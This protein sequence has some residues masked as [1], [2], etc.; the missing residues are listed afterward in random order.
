MERLKFQLNALNNLLKLAENT[1]SE[2][3]INEL[4]SDINYIQKQI[5]KKI[6]RDREKI[7]ISLINDI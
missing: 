2:S 4:K 3:Y 1:S 5:Y 7:I 6:T